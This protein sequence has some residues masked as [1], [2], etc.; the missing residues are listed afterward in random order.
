MKIKLL[1]DELEEKDLLGSAQRTVIE[2]H[3]EEKPVSLFIFLRTLLY[4]SISALV[5]GLGVLIYQ[6]I[7]TIGHSILIGLIAL[8]TTGCFFYILKNG[9]AYRPRG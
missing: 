6:N 5:G 9:V 2:M 1:L 4:I 3:E 8:A 7:N